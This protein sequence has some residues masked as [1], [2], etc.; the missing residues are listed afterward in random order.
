MDKCIYDWKIEYAEELVSVIGNKKVQDNL[1][2]GLPYPYT[3]ADAKWFINEMIN[4]NKNN[5]FSF[6]NRYHHVTVGSIS[7]ERKDNIHSKTGELGYYL[8]EEY[9]GKGIISKAIEEICNY[10]FC[11]S[12]IVRIFAEPFSYNIASC[13]ALEK[14]DFQ[15]E[16]TLVKNGY[17]NGKFID[18]KMYAK[19]K[20]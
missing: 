18:M 13:K 4:C 2:D 1:R 14:N 17:K 10:V 5:L 6:A 7:I 11:N 8:S 15:Y 20:N 12:D 9:W 3:I 19:I 16:G